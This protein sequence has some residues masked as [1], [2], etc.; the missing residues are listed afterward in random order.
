MNCK[1]DAAREA[2]AIIGLRGQAPP[3]HGCCG[4]LDT[5]GRLRLWPQRHGSDGFFAA[6]WQRRGI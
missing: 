1:L 5:A 4:S 3:T 6:V 2:F